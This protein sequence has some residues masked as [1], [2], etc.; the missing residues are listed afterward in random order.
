MVALKRFKRPYALVFLFLFAS[1]PLIVL[2][3][4]VAGARMPQP[5]YVATTQTQHYE[6]VFPNGAM[7]VYDM[8]HGQA[9]VKEV[10]LPTTGDVRGV[11]ASPATGM[12]Y[13]SYGGDGGPNGNGSLL[14]YNLLSDTVVWTKNYPFGIDS[15]G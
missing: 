3:R 14:K 7:D 4:Y 5:S 12:L 1:L 10:S 11:V 2:S 13:V 15:M 6:Y 8:D 9:L